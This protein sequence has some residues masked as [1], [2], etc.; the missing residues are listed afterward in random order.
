MLRPEHNTSLECAPHSY[1]NASELVRSGSDYILVA[2]SS[3][4]VVLMVLFV[5]E[6]CGLMDGCYIN[7]H[8]DAR[9]IYCR[10]LVF[11]PCLN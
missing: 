4:I 2:F 10:A 1:R 7:K 8:T 9:M 5:E 3:V 6:L 11:N